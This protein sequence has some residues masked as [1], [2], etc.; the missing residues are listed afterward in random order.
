MK[1]Y[2]KRIM[3]GVTFLV[4]AWTALKP[5]YRVV[6]QLR[7]SGRDYTETM[8]CVVVKHVWLK[9]QLDKTADEVVREHRRINYDTP[10]NEITLIFYRNMKDFDNGIGW[11]QYTYRADG[12]EVELI[13]EDS[14]P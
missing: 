6:F 14:W 10:T 13:A 12:N 3:V 4:I 2:W 11:R 1:K 5:E 7:S 8:V 9:K